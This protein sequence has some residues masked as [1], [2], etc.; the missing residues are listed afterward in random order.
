MTG[1]QPGL[2]SD[3]LMLVELS[4]FVQLKVKGCESYF[5]SFLL[6]YELSVDRIF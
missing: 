2:L 4:R 3:Q 5:E 1:E 6:N